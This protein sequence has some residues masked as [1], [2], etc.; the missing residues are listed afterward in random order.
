MRFELLPAVFDDLDPA[1]PMQPAVIVHI[2]GSNARI[3][4]EAIGRR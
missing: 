1:D 4:C 3:I 2:V